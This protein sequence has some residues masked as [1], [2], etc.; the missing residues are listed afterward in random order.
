MDFE[1]DIPMIAVPTLT[2][3]LRYCIYSKSSNLIVRK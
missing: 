3:A 2:L 1:L